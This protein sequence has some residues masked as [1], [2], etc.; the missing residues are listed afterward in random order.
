MGL[1]LA[2]ASSDGFVKVLVADDPLKLREWGSPYSLQV[3]DLGLN[4]ISWSKNLVKEEECVIA[5]GCKS[6]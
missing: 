3:N 2:I 4:C 5:V 1:C 6:I